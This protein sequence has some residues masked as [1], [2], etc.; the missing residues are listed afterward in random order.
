LWHTRSRMNIAES[1]SVEHV[2]MFLNPTV[3][4]SEDT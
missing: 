3:F 2:D 1:L 4:Q